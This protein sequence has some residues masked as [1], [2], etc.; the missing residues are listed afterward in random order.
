[1]THMLTASSFSLLHPDFPSG[2]WLEQSDDNPLRYAVWCPIPCGGED[3]IG[4]SDDEDEA[5]A[6]AR[7]TVRGWA[8]WDVSESLAAGESR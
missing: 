3:I 8:E 2:C 4:A 6:E 7:A 5:I 1:M